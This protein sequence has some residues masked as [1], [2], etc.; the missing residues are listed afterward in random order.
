MTAQERSTR[1]PYQQQTT[2]RKKTTSA[3]RRPTLTVGTEPT[4]ESTVT[5]TRNLRGLKSDSKLIGNKKSTFSRSTIGNTAASV[6]RMSAFNTTR[7]PVPEGLPS[8]QGL[9]NGV[10]VG[11]LVGGSTA[12]LLIGLLLLALYKRRKS[13]GLVL[14]QS[15]TDTSFD[16]LG[17]NGGR[18]ISEYMDLTELELVQV[19]VTNTIKRKISAFT[20]EDL[21]TRRISCGRLELV[22]VP[23]NSNIDSDILLTTWV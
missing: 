16:N 13:S 7:Q 18:K 22:E 4:A 2:V 10:L 17:F 19:R 8:S 14:T 21:K 20:K 15:I 9:P 23:A 1:Y 3:P 11:G 5:A 6:L 12:I